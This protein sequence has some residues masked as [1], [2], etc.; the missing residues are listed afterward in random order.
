MEATA[1]PRV[2]YLDC[3]PFTGGAQRSLLG[4]V[5]GVANRGWEVCVLSADRSPQGVL[6]QCRARQ[7]PTGD[8]R[9]AHWPVSL[10][11]L[12]RF[13]WDRAR[14]GRRL[15]DAVREWSPALV[16]ANGVR[17]GL[18]VPASIRRVAPVIL[19]D[20]DLR[21]PTWATRLLSPRVDGVVAISRCVA[22]KWSG[23]SGRGPVEVI[24]N[25]FDTAAMA[26]TQP[27]G[28]W[29]TD[30]QAL[31]AALVADLVP[32]K[33]HAVF[34]EAL[35][36]LRQAQVPAAGLV[37]GRP[38]SREG[39]DCLRELTALA[40]RLG[41]GSDVRFV[42]DASSALPWIAAASVLVSTATDEP[43]GRTVIEALALGKPVV[44]VDAAGPGE[45]L[46][47][48]PAATLTGPAPKDVA[49]GLRQWSDPRRCAAAREA[50]MAWAARY[51]REP[52]L[53]AICSL[54]R[55]VTR[56]ITS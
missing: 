52:M 17:A 39:H 26:R 48:C 18:L 6:E 21:V 50:A 36:R 44:A 34:L 30:P 9:T 5:E 19:H 16:H 51:D 53:D 7:V 54:Y 11:G 22:A 15:R 2:L 10:R 25:G 37:V 46:A 42:T 28:G 35:S 8:L 12:V 1:R 47:G 49:E 14:A 33:R 20:R 27:A 55:R 43:F 38:R 24:P 13:A 32:W 41:L 3:A 31:R 4:L 40:A 29:E 56:R 23:R 45:I